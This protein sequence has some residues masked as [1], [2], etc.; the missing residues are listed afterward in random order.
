M[1]QDSRIQQ[2]RITPL[3][4][5]TPIQAPQ[6]QPATTT[7]CSALTPTSIPESR[8]ALPSAQMHRSRKAAH[9]SLVQSTV[10][11]AQRLI[12][13]LESEQLRQPPRWTLSPSPLM[14]QTILFA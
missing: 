2:D 4:A 8:T 3:S 10:S 5:K 1:R 7:H 9:S 12:P 6:I 11:T 13:K 14:Q